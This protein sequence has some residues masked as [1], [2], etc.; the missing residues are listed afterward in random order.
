MQLSSIYVRL[1]SN[2]ILQI[3]LSEGK[4]L[5]NM[6]QLISDDMEAQFQSL[7]VE[8]GEDDAL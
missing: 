4:F 8:N 1:N 5:E 3:D 6:V 7:L 2:S